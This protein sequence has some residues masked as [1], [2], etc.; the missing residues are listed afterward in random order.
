MGLYCKCVTMMIYSLEND[1]HMN[2]YSVND[3][4]CDFVLTEIANHLNLKGKE[5]IL[6]GNPLAELI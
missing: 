6:D 4:C 5:I 1:G 2:F 3:R